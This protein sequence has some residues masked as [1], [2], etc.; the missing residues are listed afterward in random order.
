MKEQS[1]ESKSKHPIKSS[2]FPNWNHAINMHNSDFQKGII[3]YKNKN[4]LSYY[5]FIFII[6]VS[7]MV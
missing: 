2:F 3:I 1:G 6:L 7:K 5:L 4:R